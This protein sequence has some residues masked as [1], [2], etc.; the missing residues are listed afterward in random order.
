MAESTFLSFHLV[1]IRTMIDYAS[2]STRQVGAIFMDPA[3]ARHREHVDTIVISVRVMR[4]WNLY[5]TSRFGHSQCIVR[6]PSRE[7]ELSI[8]TFMAQSR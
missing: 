7:K 3:T 5:C 6:F 2:D 8:E 1:R 4:G